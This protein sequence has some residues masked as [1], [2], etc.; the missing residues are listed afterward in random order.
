MPFDRPVIGDNVLVRLGGTDD[1]P[2]LR[3]GRVVR[4][5]DFAAATVNVV[6]LLDGIDDADLCADLP[7][8]TAGDLVWRGTGLGFGPEVLQWR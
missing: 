1:A 3:P 2:E 4:V 8:Y 6:V 7:G 5:I